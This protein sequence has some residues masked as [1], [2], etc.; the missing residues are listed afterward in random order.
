MLDPERPRARPPKEREPAGGQR[1]ASG[2]GGARPKR[3]PARAL[4][5][6]ASE[7]A[8]RRSPSKLNAEGRAEGKRPARR[9]EKSASGPR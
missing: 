7:S 3:Q 4:R 5:A 8:G 1:E 9:A 6:G 2:S